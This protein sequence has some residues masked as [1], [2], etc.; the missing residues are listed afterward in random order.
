M[1]NI[2]TKFLG[3]GVGGQCVPYLEMKAKHQYMLQIYFGMSS[4][5]VGK[6][7]GKKT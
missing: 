1:K 7:E 3:V 4:Y 2:V 5:L 6:R